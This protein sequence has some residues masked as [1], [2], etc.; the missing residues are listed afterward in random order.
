[1]YVAKKVL[2]VA[3]WDPLSH[4]EKN[5]RNT[6]PSS[7]VKGT[8]AL[9]NVE[10]SMTT[11]I[12]NYS[13]FEKPER[14]KTSSTLMSGRNTPAQ[15]QTHIAQWCSHFICFL[16]LPW[17][18]FFVRQLTVRVNSSSRVSRFTTKFANRMRAHPTYGLKPIRLI[19]ISSILLTSLIDNFL[20]T[21]CFVRIY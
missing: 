7:E 1:M 10:N 15:F 6:S 21:L 3:S 5:L 19:S 18:R 9:L 13:T 16:L 4:K 11:T 8:F 14:P 12:T 2:D 20:C 17:L